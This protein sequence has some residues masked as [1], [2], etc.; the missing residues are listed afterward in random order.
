MPGRV[1]CPIYVSEY[2]N[3]DRTTVI[4][5]HRW[6]P[7]SNW[8]AERFNG[9]VHETTGDDYGNNNS[10]TEDLIA[11]LSDEHNKP[12]LHAAFGDM[13]SAVW[14]RGNPQARRAK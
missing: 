13:E 10:L 4:K 11:Q 3:R 2:V 5:T 1:S 14:H 12:P 8:I 6:H 9:T 7:G